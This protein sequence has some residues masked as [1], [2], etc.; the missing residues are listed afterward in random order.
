[1]PMEKE[2]ALLGKQVKATLE[3]NEHG[4]YVI[5]KG[6]LIGIGIDGSFEIVPEDG[7]VHYCWPYLD[8]EEV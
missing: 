7:M 2:R 1:M 4:E 8:I 6:K 3:H 5:V